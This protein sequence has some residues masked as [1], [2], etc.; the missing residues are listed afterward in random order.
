MVVTIALFAT[1]WHADPAQCRIVKS[2]RI[3]PEAQ[4]TT[5]G[6]RTLTI[7]TTARDQGR[8][9]LHCRM[10]VPHDTKTI[11]LRWD[12]AVANFAGATTRTNG[13]GLILRVEDAKREMV[14]SVGEDW[15]QSDDQHLTATMANSRVDIV[16]TAADTSPGDPMRIDLRGLRVETT[17]SDKP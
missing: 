16:I 12:S 5:D 15:V 17:S 14:R 9:E 7:S 1:L 6:G 4:W 8:V 2:G 11:T 3:G 10:R 13:S